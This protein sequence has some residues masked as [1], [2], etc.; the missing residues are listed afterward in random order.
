MFIDLNLFWYVRSLR[1][2]M[3][4]TPVRGARVYSLSDCAYVSRRL[5]RAQSTLLH[6]V[7]ISSH[8]RLRYPARE[9]SATRV[10]SR[11]IHLYIALVFFFTVRRLPFL[12][13][14][15]CVFLEPAL[16]YCYYLVVCLALKV[17]AP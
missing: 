3:W 15:S 17:L 14:F 13:F 12:S 10:F 6:R 1:R 16:L 5:R 4:L 7:P 8:A 11:G 2:Q 9:P